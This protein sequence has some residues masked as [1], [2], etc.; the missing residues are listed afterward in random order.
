MR[1]TPMEKVLYRISKEQKSRQIQHCKIRKSTIQP[2]T[3]DI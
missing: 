3:S 1:L 2:A